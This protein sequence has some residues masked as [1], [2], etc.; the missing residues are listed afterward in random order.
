[1]E[2][3]HGQQ[4]PDVVP[5]PEE[6]K[7]PE[8]DRFVT[9]FKSAYIEMTCFY[10]GNGYTG[11]FN[12][13]NVHQWFANHMK[14]CGHAEF[15][16]KVLN[17]SGFTYKEGV[18]EF[19]EDHI[20]G[21]CRHPA[22]DSICADKIMAIECV[23]CKLCICKD[24]KAKGKCPNP[25]VV[26]KDQ[27]R[28]VKFGSDRIADVTKAMFPSLVSI[29]EDVY[30]EQIIDTYS[31]KVIESIIRQAGKA[32][33]PEPTPHIEHRR[34]NI[35]EL[36][37]YTI[38]CDKGSLDVSENEYGQWVMYDDL[39]KDMRE[40]AKAPPPEPALFVVPKKLVYSE[41]VAKDGGNSEI[42]P[43]IAK[44]LANMKIECCAQPEERTEAVTIPEVTGR[45]RN[46]EDWSAE[47]PHCNTTLDFS[48]FF[49]EDD[50]ATCPKC[51]GKFKVIRCYFPNNRYMGRREGATK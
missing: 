8:D 23:D 9:G 3:P 38:F 5:K 40:K 6:H 39:V 11:E 22:M 46:E 31:P 45:A 19:L 10:C 28:K 4:K 50:I 35:Q 16:I 43:E 33:P 49:D 21:F 34:V 48:G 20:Y 1:V 47:C 7:E 13:L 32:P 41:L 15:K 37:R 18:C 27:E 17:H 29:E 14:F 30:A 36:T 44:E 51:K 25:D 12:G 26:P 24:L 2:R 42:T